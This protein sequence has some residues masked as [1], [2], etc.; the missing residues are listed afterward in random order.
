MRVREKQV[1]YR[2]TENYD[3]KI[4]NAQLR[5][6]RSAPARIASEAQIENVGD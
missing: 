4:K 2:E 1:H 6:A 5:G 3:G